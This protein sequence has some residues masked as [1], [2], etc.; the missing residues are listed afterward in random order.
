MLIS[1][2]KLL[3]TTKPRTLTSA[4]LGYGP[5]TGQA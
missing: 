3:E 1:E 2:L 5:D 4:G